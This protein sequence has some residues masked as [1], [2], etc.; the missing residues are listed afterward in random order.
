MRVWHS[1]YFLIPLQSFARI[2]KWLDYAKSSKNLNIVAGGNCD[3][4]KGYFVEPTI[5]ETRDP[6]DAIM[7]EVPISV[8]A[9]IFCR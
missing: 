4:K 6:Q 9:S 8:T 7:N 2:K 3:D 5:I 1:L